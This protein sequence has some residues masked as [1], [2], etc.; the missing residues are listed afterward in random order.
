MQN[1]PNSVLSFLCSVTAR[2]CATCFCFHALRLLTRLCFY[3][4]SAGE[5]VL[6]SVS[7]LHPE[8]L[9]QLL[10]S[11][12]LCLIPKATLP[13]SFS[14]LPLQLEAVG[15]VFNC[16]GKDYDMLAAPFLDVVG[17]L[18]E[19]FDW[20]VDYFFLITHKI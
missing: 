20:S 9:S 8:R 18:T 17:Y 10:P 12:L 14:C 5:L 15:K 3:L 13:F 19:Y 11:L 7:C 1:V 4:Q 6:G 16:Q 2:W